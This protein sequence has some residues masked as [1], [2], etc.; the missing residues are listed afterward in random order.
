MKK[1]IIF[2][3]NI[4]EMGGSQ[5]YVRDK[6]EFITDKGYDAYVV[7]NGNKSKNVL[8][9]DLKKF[10]DYLIKELD[11][12]P[13]FYSGNVINEVLKKIIVLCNIT[14]DDEIIIESN[15]FILACWA[16]LF[17]K[18]INARH[19]C[20][21]LQEK[22]MGSMIKF[23]DFKN[24]RLELAG[25]YKDSL[26]NMF[27][28]YKN[29]DLTNN[30]YLIATNSQ[31]VSDY[32][33]GIDFSRKEYDYVIGSIGRLE[34]PYVNSMIDSVVKFS[35]CVYPKKVKLLLLASKE[36]DSLNKRIIDRQCEAK[37]LYI[38]I[39]GIL[40][41]IPKELFKN[42]DVFVSSATSAQI[43]A[44]EY[45]PTITVDCNDYEA[46]GVLGYTTKEDLYRSNEKE[47]YSIV[48]WLK[49]ILIDNYCDTHIFNSDLVWLFKQKDWKK[50]LESHID[51]M[52]ESKDQKKEYYDVLSE[53]P[54]RFSRKRAIIC[55]LFGYNIMKMLMK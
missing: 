36:Y 22:F 45:V 30:R 43:S 21:I 37:N 34:K 28:G 33:C 53:I 8:I 27:K 7:S 49:K 15:S 9:G 38:E 14:K 25:T 5:L 29:I 42:V 3:F 44:S 52:N 18:K 23:M 20:Y 26:V 48:E 46:I 24:N 51:F 39:T 4:S 40:S 17:A 31:I 50:I 55:K 47:N 35:N 54:K 6:I 2:T 1:Y 41:P 12:Y 10:Q 11:Y 16:E 19:I 13:H 32:D